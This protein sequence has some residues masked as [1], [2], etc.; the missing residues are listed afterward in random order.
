MARDESDGGEVKTT[1]ISKK[2]D[3]KINFSS[4][5]FPPI[6]VALTSNCTTSRNTFHN[7]K[8]L[9]TITKQSTKTKVSI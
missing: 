6:S 3:S 2:I 7:F 9:A 4:D 5:T 1:F 8:I